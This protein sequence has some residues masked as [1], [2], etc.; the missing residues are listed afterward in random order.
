MVMV[1]MG[2]NEKGDWSSRK[3]TDDDSGLPTFAFGQ[4]RASSSSSSP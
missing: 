4:P 1:M 3:V 2:R